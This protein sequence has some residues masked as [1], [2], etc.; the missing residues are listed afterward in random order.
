MPYVAIIGL[1]DKKYVPVAMFLKGGVL[2]AFE[3][4]PRY[5][6]LG[7]DHGSTGE[8][9]GHWVFPKEKEIARFLVEM[10]YDSSCGGSRN[11]ALSIT[12]LDCAHELG[13][14]MPVSYPVFM[15]AFSTLR[16]L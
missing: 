7:R 12:F 13:S 9:A 3:K 2:W 10:A 15:P 1:V 8:R 11:P 14:P 16:I 4:Y 6:C 5:L